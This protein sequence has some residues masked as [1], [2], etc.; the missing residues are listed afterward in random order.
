MASG[1]SEQLGL[2]PDFRMLSAGECS[3]LV[4]Q[5][6]SIE[7][8]PSEVLRETTSKAKG[9]YYILS[10]SVELVSEGAEGNRLIIDTLHEGALEGCDVFDKMELSS[11]RLQAGAEPALLQ[12]LSKSNIMAFLIAHPEIKEKIEDA[13]RLREVL[14]FLIQ[15]KSLNGIPREGLASLSRHTIQKD[16]SAG[17][18]VIKQGEHDDSLFLVKS[19]WFV[20]TRDEAPSVRIDTPGPGAILGEIAVLTGDPRGA[21]V[22]A[23]EDS[24]IYHVPG[25]AF[26]TLIEEHKELS[27]N[28]TAMMHQRIQESDEIMAKAEARAKA[29]ADEV[30]ANE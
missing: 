30:V 18:Q 21:N 2:H 27:E 7:V 12:Y 20:V 13:R 26:R 22:I 4:R 9:F 17:T 10:G 28:L 3:Q 24:V 16:V 14:D 11:Y 23:G 15:A 29:E 6:A 8:R 25:P 1:F 19:G 5:A